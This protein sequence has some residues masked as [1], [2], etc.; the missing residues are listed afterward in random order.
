MT[1]LPGPKAIAE[2]RAQ[3]RVYLLFAERMIGIK[4]FYSPPRRPRGLD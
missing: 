3:G 4:N 2:R 1:S